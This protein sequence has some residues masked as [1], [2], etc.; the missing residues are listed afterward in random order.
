MGNLGLWISSWN[1]HVAMCA[2]TASG[3]KISLPLGEIISH[4]RKYNT[5][6]KMISSQ[7]W[8]ISCVEIWEGGGGVRAPPPPPPPWV[9]P[10][11]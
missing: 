10:P 3:I 4:M 9:P 11:M 6:F 1:S 2:M 7:Y 8:V 5:Y